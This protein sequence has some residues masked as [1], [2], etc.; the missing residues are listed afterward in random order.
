MLNSFLIFDLTLSGNLTFPVDSYWNCSAQQF[1]LRHTEKLLC[2]RDAGGYEY[3]HWGHLHR[4]GLFLHLLW[5]LSTNCWITLGQR[6]FFNQA[7]ELPVQPVGVQRSLAQGLSIEKMDSPDIIN[8][9]RFPYILKLRCY[10][11]N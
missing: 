9:E 11:N 10:D 3:H 5:D 6:L 8:L 7:G 2:H 1:A 4:A